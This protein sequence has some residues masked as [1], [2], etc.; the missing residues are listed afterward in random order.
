ML[1]SKQALLKIQLNLF[2]NIFVIAQLQKRF[3]TLSRHFA[4]EPYICNMSPV[5]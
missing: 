4:D 3:I 2:D 5:K 1:H